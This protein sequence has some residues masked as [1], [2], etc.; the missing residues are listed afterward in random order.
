[1]TEEQRQEQLDFYNANKQNYLRFNGDFIALK[2]NKLCC[3][4]QSE[5]EAKRLLLSRGYNGDDF[6]LIKVEQ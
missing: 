5:D 6:L 4:A 3:V 1:M 2:D